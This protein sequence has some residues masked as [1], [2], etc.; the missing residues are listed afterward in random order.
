MKKTMFRTALV[1]GLLALV[2]LGAGAQGLYWESDMTS[3]KNQGSGVSKTW[4]MPKML[5]D[6]AYALGCKVVK[7]RR[8]L[9]FALSDIQ[10]GEQ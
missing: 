1:V 2:T 5:G 6:L 8:D 3:E 4:Y 9:L 7:Y 10:L